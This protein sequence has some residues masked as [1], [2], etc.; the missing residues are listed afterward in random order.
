MTASQIIPM[1]LHLSDCLRVF[2]L[3]LEMPSLGDV[4]DPVI[5][6]TC[7]WD[8]LFIRNHIKLMRD[9]LMLLG[10]K[11]LI[12]NVY[13]CIFY[14]LSASIIGKHGLEARQSHV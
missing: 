11:D 4:F 6:E 5:N 12:R 1:E 2:L 14:C 13:F 9:E 3:F 8:K 7:F 10:R